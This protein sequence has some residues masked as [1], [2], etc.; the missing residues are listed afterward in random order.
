MATDF[1]PFAAGVGT[2]V[3]SQST[4]AAAT[5]RLD[6]WRS[7][8]LPHV[9][10]NKVLR[11]TSV[12]SAAMAQLV[13]ASLNVDVFDDGNVTGLRDKLASTFS[14]AGLPYNPNTPYPAGSAGAALKNLNTNGGSFLTAEN[15]KSVLAGALSP[16]ELTASLSARINLI[17]A[18]TTGLVTKVETL[19]TTYGSTASAATSASNAASSLIAAVNAAN[20][21]SISAG[22]AFTSETNANAAAVTAGTG[23]NT[24]TTQASNAATSASSANG[25][26]TSASTS[27]NTASTAATNAVN[28]AN[29]AATSASNASTSAGNAGTYASAA[30][31]SATNAN[32]SASNA[33]T[34]AESASSSATSATGSAGVASTK[35]AAASASADAAVG[36]A[37]AASVSASNASTFANNANSYA[38]AASSSANAASTFASSASTS[39]NNTASSASN[40]AGSASSASTFASAA[41]TSSTTAGNFAVAANTSAGNASTFANN[42]SNSAGAAADYY[43]NTVSATGSLTAAVSTEA[44]TRATEDGKLQAQYVLKVGTTRGDGKAVVAGIGLASTTSGTIGQ[45]EIL[46]QADRLVFANPTDLNGGLVTMMTIGN[47]NGVGNQVVIRS[48]LIADLT[49]QTLMIA[50]NAV[51]VPVGSELTSDVTLPQTGGAGNTTIFSTTLTGLGANQTVAVIADM[52][53]Y[54]SNSESPLAF[55]SMT[56]R[57]NGSIVRQWSTYVHGIAQNHVFV[58]IVTSDSSG[59]ATVELSGTSSANFGIVASRNSSVIFGSGGTSI[60]VI[61][62]KK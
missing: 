61:G 53:V 18:P 39:A 14:L 52:A 40:A 24:A 19:L 20:A 36:S 26:A 28:A 55:I 12:M 6:G 37:N 11:Q 57:V 35:A 49:V 59:T 34:S 58:G 60:L 56:L 46:F 25:F 17:D 23:A 27:A 62:L 15:L 38:S 47:V 33:N 43:N 3:V 2:D 4:Y 29:A 13:S 10:I 48:A 50:N 32:T 9:Q 30:N 41:S 31:T 42:A 44:T 21:A 22:A 16:S 45:S 7:G 8:I 5:W 51:T 54:I 1:L